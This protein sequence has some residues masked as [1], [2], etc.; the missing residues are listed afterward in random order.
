MALFQGDGIGY[1]LGLSDLSKLM[2]HLTE[3]EC[4]PLKYRFK[5]K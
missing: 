5:Q 3:K 2:F 4:L 1:T